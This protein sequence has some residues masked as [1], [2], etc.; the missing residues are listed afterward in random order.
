MA[1]NLEIEN[2]FDLHLEAFGVEP[3]VTGINYAE[4]GSLVERLIESIQ[5]GVPYVEQPV[6]E[7]VST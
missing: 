4:S 5:T 6:P 3:V 2:I 7:E 1:E